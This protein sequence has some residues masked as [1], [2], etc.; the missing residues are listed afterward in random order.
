[1]AF[2]LLL[3][4]LT[5]C[6]ALPKDLSGKMFSF[7][8]QTNTAYVRLTTSRQDLKAVT[9]CLRFFTD[10]QTEYSLFSLA[11]PSTINGFLLIKQPANDKID[12]H[13]RNAWAHFAGQN[14]IMNTWHSICATWDSASGL[15]QVWLDGKPSNMKFISSGSSINGPII[16]VLGQDQDSYGGSFEL[17]QTFVGMMS[18]VHMWDRTLSPC[19]IQD[20]VDQLSFPPGNVLN[21]ESLEFQIIGR[22][23]LRDKLITC[24]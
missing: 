9:V 23:L 21:W 12:L 6:A 17:R 13:V 24:R 15:G 22:V 8:E 5:V 20:Y 11:T 7:P 18:D 14:Y 3:A 19:E 10:I 16:I 2:L 4:M 1:M